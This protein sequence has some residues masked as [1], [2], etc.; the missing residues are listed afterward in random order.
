VNRTELTERQRRDLEGWLPKG[1]S[2]Y[3]DL[4]EKRADVWLAMAERSAR[5]TAKIYNHTQAQLDRMFYR[6]NIHRNIAIQVKRYAPQFLAVLGDEVELSEDDDLLVLTSDLY[7]LMERG[8]P[9]VALVDLMLA[10]TCDYGI[11]FSFIGS[12]ANPLQSY[13]DRIE[14]NLDHFRYPKRPRRLKGTVPFSVEF[15]LE[16]K[17]HKLER[18]YGMTYHLAY[19]YTFLKRFD[20]TQEMLGQLL[21][22][23]QHVRLHVLPVADYLKIRGK[24]RFS[25][26][27][28]QRRVFRFFEDQPSLKRTIQEDIRDYLGPNIK[29]RGTPLG[30]S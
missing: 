13:L 26:L 28:L 12:C 9:A 30:V 22:A 2:D 3:S 6:G 27:S 23:M 21:R 17:S 18:T 15:L 1:F 14:E 10:C 5:D 16:V 7:S 11:T 24:G 20:G 29:N 4:C 8:C 25:G 19:F